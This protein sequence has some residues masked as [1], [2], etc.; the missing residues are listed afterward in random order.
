MVEQ[1]IL[2]LSAQKAFLGRITANMRLITVKFN[3][4]SIIVTCYATEKCEA[5]VSDLLS[6]ASTEIISDF[7]SL[8]IEEHIIRGE[9]PL[10]VEDVLVNGWIYQRYE[11]TLPA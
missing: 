11:A 2:R 4:K 9:M 7:P 1:S 5:I 10:P 3:N 8:N 6:E